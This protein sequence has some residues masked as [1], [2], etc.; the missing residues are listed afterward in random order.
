VQNIR[1][2]SNLGATCCCP[3]TPPSPCMH[4]KKGTSMHACVW[5]KEPMA[6]LCQLIHACGCWAAQQTHVRRRQH[7]QWG[8]SSSL[9]THSGDTLGGRQ[10]LHQQNHKGQHIKGST[11]AG[12]ALGGHMMLSAPNQPCCCHL[13]NIEATPTCSFC[14]RP[15]G[16]Q[17]KCLLALDWRRSEGAPQQQQQPKGPCRRPYS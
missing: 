12:H 6:A 1:A 17:P 10:H 16:D 2:M 3:F 8:P 13:S 14:H 11:K 4:K 15:T 9:Q 5:H 7:A